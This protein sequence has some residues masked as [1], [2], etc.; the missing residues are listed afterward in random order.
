MA[1]RPVRRIYVLDSSPLIDL[2]LG[3]SRLFPIA[4]VWERLAEMVKA[5][6]IKMP[7]EALNEIRDEDLTAWVKRQAG[8]VVPTA[9]VIASAM[10]VVR[11]TGLC[12]REKTQT[13]ADPFVVALADVLRETAEA[14]LLEDIDVVVVTQELPKPSKLNIPSVCEA[15]GLPVVTLSGFFEL[16]GITAALSSIP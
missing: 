4:G 11:E 12:D 15:R 14:P 5:G 3:M 2:S 9:D 6:Q 16:E 13:D 1:V 8:M 10:E 7:Q